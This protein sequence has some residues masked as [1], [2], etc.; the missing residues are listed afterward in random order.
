MNCLVLRRVVVYDNYFKCYCDLPEDCLDYD[1]C[2]DVR[3]AE[4]I[5]LINE[6]WLQ[7]IYRRY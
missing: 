7:D 1:I 5:E 6:R 3:E 4:D 2:K